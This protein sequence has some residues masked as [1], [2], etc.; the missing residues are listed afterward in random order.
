M[1]VFF[2]YENKSGTRRLT[3][4]VDEFLK[5]DVFSYEQKKSTIKWGDAN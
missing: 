1:C 4:L 3:F 5:S 2:N